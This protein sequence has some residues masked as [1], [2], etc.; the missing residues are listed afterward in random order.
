MVGTVELG[1]HFVS[2]SGQGV[3]ER[4]RDG[5]LSRVPGCRS[6]CPGGRWESS[7]AC[8][9]GG[10]R[11]GDQLGSLRVIG[12]D[13]AGVDPATVFPECLAS[14]GRALRVV[15]GIGVPAGDLPSELLR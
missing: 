8:L 6:P 12:P 11:S 10:R 5:L 3:Y 13:H 2:G 14:S 1:Q 9:A 15:T 4:T 7:L